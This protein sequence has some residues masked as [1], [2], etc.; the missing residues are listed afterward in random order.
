MVYERVKEYFLESGERYIALLLVIGVIMAVV[1]IVAIT[2]LFASW[3]VGFWAALTQMNMPLYMESIQTFVMLTA[4]Y[5]GVSVI[6]DYLVGML[7]INWRNWLTTKLIDKYT[8]HEGNN[9]LDLERHSSELENPAQR[10]QE[11]VKLFVDQTFSLGI[12]LFQSILLV[13]TFIGTLWAVGGSLT[14]VSITIPGYLV[15]VAV[16]YAAMSTGLTYLIGQPLTTL[17]NDQQNLEADFRSSIENLSH[18][19]ES[20]AQD[21][22]EI[23]YQQALNDRFRAV[24]NN[25]YQLLGVRINLTAFNAFYQQLSGVIPYVLSAP[26]YFSGMV[27]LGQLMQIGFAFSQIQE[28][29]GWF[30]NSYETFARYRTSVERITALENGMKN[31]G[32]TTTAKSIV[33]QQS[34]SCEL[35]VRNLNIQ[36]P[37]STDF[38]IRELNLTF[39][40]GEN[41]LIKGRSGLGKSTLFKVIAGTWGY[42]SGDV[43]LNDNKKMFF[44]P[45]RPSLPNDTLKA[46]LAYPEPVGTYTN[47]QYAAVLR[48]VGDLDRFIDDLDTKAPWSKRLSLGQ[49]QRLS[50]ARAILQKPDWL[51]LDEATASLDEETEQHMYS[52]VKNKLSST[53]FVSIAHRSTVAPFHDRVVTLAADENNKS[54]L[55][56]E[57]N[58]AGRM[59]AVNDID[60]RL[61]PSLPP[62]DPA[63]C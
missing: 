28:A 47:E 57:N 15:W 16:L 30:S 39:R 51:F 9:Y 20:I 53:T 55:S 60:L 25:A 32:L 1:G 41:T 14:I 21:H 44:L 12:N 35:S 6:Q 17:T 42:G 45:Q 8:S 26:L 34:E 23:Y 13:A 40:P 50:F 37:S 38:M 36:Y 43:S 33:V 63:M 27:G 54:C 11:E 48:E 58:F 24:N 5:I 3:Q 19:A 10:I 62:L 18:D 46:V 22:G 61:N 2:A 59:D 56:E 49:Q 52:L 4:S 31:G 7:S 29:F